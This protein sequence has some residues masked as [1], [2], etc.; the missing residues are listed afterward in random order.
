M[1]TIAVPHAHDRPAEARELEVP[2]RRDPLRARDLHLRPQRRQ[3]V[4]D[5]LNLVDPPRRARRPGRPLGRRQVARWSTCCCAS[6]NSSRAASASTART[7]ASVTQESLRARD[8]HGDAGHLAAAPLD[9]RQHPLR[10]ARRDDGRD[11]GRGAQGA[12]A[13]VHP[14]PAGLEGPHRLRRA[15][16]RARRQALRRA[17]PAHRDRARGAEG[18]ADPGAGRGHLGARQRGRARDP[19]AAARPD[20]GQDGDRHRA[21]AVHHRAHGPA[22]RAGRRAASSSRART[23]NCSRWTATTR[24]CGRT[25]PAASSPRTCPTTRWRRQ[26]RPP[27]RK[28]A[29]WTR[30][31]PRSAP[32]P[33]P[34]SN[35]RPRAPEPHASAMEIAAFLHR[36]HP[37]RRPPPVGVRASPT[38]PGSTRCCS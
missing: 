25:S 19:G 26:C 15:R 18:R 37:P 8:R 21:P 29:R 16:R 31:A 38:A 6:T 17:A 22:D 4:L 27:R 24:G 23:P 30:C 32:G 33:T 1:E 10:P 5:D 35:R 11:R 36:L 28:T 20:G 12:G 9:R 3:A 13:R 2:Q 7:C 14:R 34:T